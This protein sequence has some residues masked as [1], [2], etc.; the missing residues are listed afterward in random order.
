M[1]LA[2]PFAAAL[3]AAAV[4]SASNAPARAQGAGEREVERRAAC[5]THEGADFPGAN[6][7]C[8]GPELDGK[9]CDDV[10]DRAAAACFG[11]ET[12]IWDRVL[13]RLKGAKSDRKG[14]AEAVAQA[15]A[16]F[17]A[18]RDRACALY[19]GFGINN[20]RVDFVPQCR[21]RLTVEFAKDAYLQLFSP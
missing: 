17:R 4:L 2:P 3:L 15:L 13:D 5:I 16:A 6:R 18:H 10:A 12:A 7:G 11:R 8:D 9:V 20:E 19:R 21:L 1:R 14:G